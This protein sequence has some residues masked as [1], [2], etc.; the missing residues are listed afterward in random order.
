M[1]CDN[2]DNEAT[3]H[4]L[5]VKSGIKVEKHLCDQCAREQGIAVQSHPPIADL[6]TKHLMQQ[7]MAGPT[8]PPP[9]KLN[10]CSSCGL[11]YAEFRQGGLLGCPECY[12]AFEEQLGPLLER[13]HEGATH[14]VGKAPRRL[15]LATQ[16]RGDGDEAEALIGGPDE[17]AERITLLRKHLQQAVHAEQYERAAQIRDELAQFGQEPIPEQAPEPNGPGDGPSS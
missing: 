16:S 8:R 13:A 6:I 5:T 15:L 4:E 14:H 2:C 11:S 9:R 10:A 17:R 1:K 12:K 3:V 7:S